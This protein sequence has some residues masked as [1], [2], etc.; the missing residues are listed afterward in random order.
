MSWP[1]KPPLGSNLDRWL[2]KKCPLTSVWR[3]CPPVDELDV[4]GGNGAFP[5]FEDA[6]KRFTEG[7]RALRHWFI[8]DSCIVRYGD[9]GHVRVRVTPEYDGDERGFRLSLLRDGKETHFRQWVSLSMALRCG[10]EWLP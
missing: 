4:K 9:D 7:A 3:I 6:R 8:G 5:T 2:I 10:E 1:P